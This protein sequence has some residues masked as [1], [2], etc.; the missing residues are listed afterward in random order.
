MLGIVLSYGQFQKAQARRLR[1]DPGD[2][3]P[4]AREPFLGEMLDALYAAGRQAGTHACARLLR[5]GRTNC[6]VTSG[7][8]GLLP[9]SYKRS[10]N[11]FIWL[12]WVC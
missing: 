5:A 2:L 7:V 12:E 3:N 1:P 9:I 11:M 6:R 4:Y 8:Y 10:I